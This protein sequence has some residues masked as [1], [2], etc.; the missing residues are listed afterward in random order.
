MALSGSALSSIV[1]LHS[2]VYDLESGR[3]PIISSSVKAEDNSRDKEQIAKSKLRNEQ[4]LIH[5]AEDQDKYHTY[6]E[7]MEKKAQIYEMMSSG[8]VNDEEGELLV[9]FSKKKRSRNNNDNNEDT[10]M[11]I[12]DIKCLLDE[13]GKKRRRIEEQDEPQFGR[14]APP[15]II[16]KSATTSISDE[17]NLDIKDQK[18]VIFMRQRKNDQQNDILKLLDNQEALRKEKAVQSFMNEKVLSQLTDQSKNQKKETEKQKQN[19]NTNIDEQ[20]F[21][22]L[23]QSLRQQEKISEQNTQGKKQTIKGKNKPRSDPTLDADADVEKFISDRRDAYQRREEEGLRIEAEK[24]IKQ[25]EKEKQDNSAQTRKDKLR[26]MVQ[27]QQK[28]KSNT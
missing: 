20:E 25:T 21:G 24:R 6:M 26:A 14:V 22:S 23:D 15:S 12:N 13:N 27:A 3:R 5:A 16:Q 9:D 19:N 28:K 11:D 7:K 4:D 8:G 1:E 10:Q 18:P 17:M 2:L